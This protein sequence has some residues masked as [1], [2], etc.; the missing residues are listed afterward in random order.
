MICHLLIG[1]VNEQKQTPAR[2]QMSGNM[3]N[4][5]RGE[6]A[7][8]CRPRDDYSIEQK[9]CFV[10]GSGLEFSDFSRWLRGCSMGLRLHRDF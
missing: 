4:A 8:R 5:V 2:A 3:N 10:L 7:A 1:S 6:G 9:F